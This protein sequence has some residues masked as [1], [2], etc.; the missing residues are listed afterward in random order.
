[1]NVAAIEGYAK[2][3]A[4]NAFGRGALQ[5][6][7]GGTLPDTCTIAL[8]HRRP[9]G[10]DFIGMLKALE[11]LANDLPGGNAAGRIKAR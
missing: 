9:P 6:P 8:G 4:V 3:E 1:V 10:R 11:A 7:H 2:S 5:T